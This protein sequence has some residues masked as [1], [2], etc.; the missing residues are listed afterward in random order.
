MFD[1]DDLCVEITPRNWINGIKLVHL[2]SDT[3]NVIILTKIVLQNLLPLSRSKFLLTW[4]WLHFD[5]Q[6]E[7]ILGDLACIA[8]TH[9]VFL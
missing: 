5:Q 6:F 3:H 9:I 7:S 8:I 4:F 1:P 2:C